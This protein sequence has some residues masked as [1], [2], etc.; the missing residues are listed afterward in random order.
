MR[1]I[2]IVI[3]IV[4]CLTVH[5]AAIGQDKTEYSWYQDNVLGFRLMFPP[6]WKKQ[7]KQYESF[8]EL[9]KSSQNL[10]I[11]GDEVYE[12]LNLFS[13]AKDEINQL[14]ISCSPYTYKDDN[15]YQSYVAKAFELLILSLKDKDIPFQYRQ[16]RESVNGIP[17]Y[18][19]HI[20][21]FDKGYKNLKL[22]Q[23]LYILFNE[24]CSY[25]ILIAFN[26][27]ANLE[28]LQKSLD[29]FVF[30]SESKSGR[31]N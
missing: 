2:C 8:D 29:S 12:S 26:S 5:L 10:K 1:R 18:G 22:K 7:A 17:A 3:V 9:K 15:A 27:D 23:R 25:S 4:Q 24:G 14:G 31:Q 11:I 21:V 30:G 13:F 28:I 20:R 16:G 19:I 6:S